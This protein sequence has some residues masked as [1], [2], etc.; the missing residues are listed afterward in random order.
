[1]YLSQ[2]TCVP[3]DP[4]GTNS[5]WILVDPMTCHYRLLIFE[6]PPGQVPIDYSYLY[7]PGCDPCGTWDLNICGPKLTDVTC[8][9]P[10][11][12]VPPQPKVVP[13]GISWAKQFY[14]D[15]PVVIWIGAAVAAGFFFG[16][17]K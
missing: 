13:G 4:V 11:G 1:M 10:G 7:P 15:Y 6:V 16:K 5:R 17:G 14:Q 12:E 3:P 8:W 2:P 9:P